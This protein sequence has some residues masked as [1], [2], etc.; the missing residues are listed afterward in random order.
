MGALLNDDL[1]VQPYPARLDKLQHHGIGLW[2]VIAEA[3]RQGSLDGAI[4]R[5][6]GN[7]LTRLICTL[8]ALQA[9]AFNGKTAARMGR[10]QLL[11]LGSRVALLDL[12]SSSPA[13][14]LDAGLKQAA[15][16]SL[17]PYIRSAQ[18][19]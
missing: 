10:R 7:D 4:R 14:T 16:A 15:W 9:V 3:E 18:T 2:D 19:G 6:V 8:P 13:Y 12:P 17:L 11:A 1:H 5:E